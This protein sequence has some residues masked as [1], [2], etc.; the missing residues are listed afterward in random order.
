MTV[1]YVDPPRT[2]GVRGSNDL[3]VPGVAAGR[4]RPAQPRRPELARPSGA[5]FCYRGTGV[6]M[7]SAVH[8]KRPVSAA[9]TLLLA[10]VAAAITL[11]LGVMAHIGSKVNNDFA[12]LS[13]VAPDK[14]T[15]VRVEPG[16]SLAD[17]A[18]R[19]APDAPVRQIVDR[20]RELNV[21]ESSTLTSGQT[22]IVPVG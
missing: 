15:V 8:R 7:S 13:V 2:R 16:E 10:V 5:P 4:R 21:L 22:L 17:V 11:W 1:L 20:I 12:D 9:T 19:L 18:A 6:K 14:L 3:T